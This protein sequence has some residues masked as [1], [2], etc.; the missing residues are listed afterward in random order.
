MVTNK[1]VIKEGNW[2]EMLACA[3]GGDRPW[4][5]RK[6][7]RRKSVGKGAL[8]K[9][10]QYRLTQEPVMTRLHPCDTALKCVT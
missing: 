7:G 5:R 2:L 9:K 6:V 3:E 4:H 1:Q 10:K 8:G